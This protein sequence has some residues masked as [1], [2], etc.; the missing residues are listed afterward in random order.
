MPQNKI[1]L[2]PYRICETL[3][4]NL[5]HVVGRVVFR[6]GRPMLV[7][8]VGGLYLEH[9]LCGK[10]I[11]PGYSNDYTIVHVWEEERTAKRKGD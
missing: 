9:T 5:A 3:S 6:P 1:S 11:T 10:V 8:H 4:G 7:E 2:F